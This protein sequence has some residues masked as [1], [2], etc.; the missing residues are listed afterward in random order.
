MAT[1][2]FFLPQALTEVF[3]SSL[4]DEMLIS[5]SI[6]PSISIK[7]FGVKFYTEALTQGLNSSMFSELQILCRETYEEIIALNSKGQV[8][9]ENFEYASVTYAAF[10]ETG[11]NLMFSLKKTYSLTISV[12][13]LGPK[14]ILIKPSLDFA[15]SNLEVAVKEISREIRK[16]KGITDGANFI[17]I[18]NGK[19]I[20]VVD[21]CGDLVW[22]EPTLSRE[23]HL[24]ALFKT[25]QILFHLVKEKR[26][27][28]S[29]LPLFLGDF[30]SH[31]NLEYKVFCKNLPPVKI[32]HFES[33]IDASLRFELIF[34]SNLFISMINPQTGI[35]YELSEMINPKSAI[36]KMLTEITREL[37]VKAAEF[38]LCREYINRINTTSRIG[39][40]VTDKKGGKYTIS[41][42]SSKSI[43]LT[44]SDS[45][46][47]EFRLNLEDPIIQ[48]DV[49]KLFIEMFH[50]H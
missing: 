17:L 18:F 9:R 33:K 14:S 35:S 22:L 11:M 25:N 7:A 43:T 26:F 31:E 46:F 44:L 29:R 4:D 32:I 36:N 24:E 45:P 12:D 19:K 21:D 49:K 38:V 40:E 10:K 6:P 8:I 28:E 3:L 34:C 23:L 27:N 42:L 2:E 16:P 13:G 20:A 37:R 48:E 41:E 50:T 5:F 47:T 1:N 30:S 39:E 15:T